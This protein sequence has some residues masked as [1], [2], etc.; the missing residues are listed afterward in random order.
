MKDNTP[1]KTLVDLYRLAGKPAIDGL[2]LTLA[3]PY[4]TEA[5]TILAHFMSA[6]YFQQFVADG[7]FYIDGIE[8][9]DTNLP[10]T[11]VEI[12]L[13]LKLPRDSVHRFHKSVTELIKFSSVRNGDFPDDFYICDEDFHS[14]DIIVP[15]SIRKVESI[16]NLI[17]SLSKLAHY[18]DKKA[19]DGEPRLVFIQGSEG[20]SK[21][22][23]LQPIITKEML[24]YTDV[25]CSIVE[26]LQDDFSAEDVNHHV[27]KRGIF[28]NT[29]VEFVN[30]NGYDFE[31]L[32]KH[33][34]E[35]RLSYDNN[36]SVYLSGFSFHK[37]RKEVAAAE[38]EFAEK[39][40]KTINEL[41]TK[42]LAVPISLLAAVGLWKLHNLTEQF[43]ALTGIIFTSVIINLII[44]SQSKQLRRIIHSRD[45]V[46]SPFL[47]KLKNYPNELQN[48]IS[49]AT[50]ELNKN[51]KFSKKVLCLFYVLC[52]IPTVVGIII[53]FLKYNPTE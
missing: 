22:A 26:K 42:I 16:C 21:S 14:A 32:I 9:Q 12:E 25:D 41:T 44:L 3:L 31:Q 4:S 11:W 45:M 19:T 28:R 10:D 38:L 43:I 49:R 7:E 27:E 50:D 53:I 5:K 17:K 29:L 20:R 30:D 51:E 34:T 47:L 37:S 2:H 36:L 39:T 13:T 52:W 1:L 8:I 33:W 46:F 35:F 40:A 48:D 24:S 23:L 15:A 6:N 18:H